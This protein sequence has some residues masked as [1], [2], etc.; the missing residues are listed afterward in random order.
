MPFREGSSQP[1]VGLLST[2]TV[3]SVPGEY[4]F[5]SAVA[6]VIITAGASRYCILMPYSYELH[7]LVNSLAYPARSVAGFV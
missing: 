4:N 1:Q 6:K 2:P 7:L 3:S 5:F